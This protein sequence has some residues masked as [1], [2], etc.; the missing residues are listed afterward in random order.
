MIARYSRPAMQAIWSDEGKL[1]RWLD[2][3]LAALEGDG[4]ATAGLVL[5]WIGVAL[6]VL[7]LLAFLFLALLLLGF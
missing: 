1:A 4:L 7:G 2:V 3:E 6:A 5:G